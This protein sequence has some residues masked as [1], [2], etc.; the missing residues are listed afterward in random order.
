MTEPRIT[1]A[2]AAAGLLESAFGTILAERMQDVPI[3]NPALAVEAVGL[4]EWQGH[5]LGALVTPW[6]INLV[7]LPGSAGWRAVP[8]RDSVWYA[9]P[10]GRFEF[11]AGSEPGLGP[12][13]ACSLFSPVQEFG[14]HETARE[15]ARVALESLFDPALLGEAPAREQPDGPQLSRRDFLRGAAATRS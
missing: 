5:W 14:D 11:I 9:F 8:D 1:D 15:T 6:F 7:V 3:L 2:A 4:R 13:H 12:Y 10:S